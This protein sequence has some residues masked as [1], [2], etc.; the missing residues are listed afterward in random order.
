M[1]IQRNIAARNVGELDKATRAVGRAGQAR[2]RAK[3]I[4][5]QSIAAIGDTAADVLGEIGRQRQERED[6]IATTKAAADFTLEV[7]DLRTELET[8][9]TL[10]GNDADEEM[11]AYFAQKATELREKY[12]SEFE[13]SKDAKVR[14]EAVLTES[15]ARHQA[16]VNEQAV[17]RR[18]QRQRDEGLA[19]VDALV[20]RGF[21][22]EAVIVLEE[23]QRAGLVDTQNAASAAQ[24]IRDRA[25]MLEVQ[26][27]Y[28]ERYAA[29]TDLEYIRELSDDEKLRERPEFREK[30]LDFAK[31]QRQNIEF[32]LNR[33]QKLQAESDRLRRQDNYL[34][35][36]NALEQNQGDLAS[37]REDPRY[38]DLTPEQRSGLQAAA[39]RIVEGP[40][41]DD[42]TIWMELNRT[43]AE[44][45]ARMTPD[46]F[47]RDYLSRMGPYRDRA[48]ALYSAAQ[49]PADAPGIMTDKQ[50]LD[51]A[52][53]LAFPDLADEKWSDLSDDERRRVSTFRVRLEQ[54]I[55][56]ATRAKGRDLDPVEKQAIID[57]EIM[58]PLI[59]RG[60]KD[61]IPWNESTALATAYTPQEIEEIRA[62]G[63]KDVAV[64]LDDIPE[65]KIRR[66]VNLARSAGAVKP[67]LPYEKARSAMSDRMERAFAAAQLGATDQEITDILMG[68]L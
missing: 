66:M 16:Q 61:W 48:V 18:V 24:E 38:M 37:V 28:R 17:K 42:S 62:G 68:R 2:A 5:G 15:L 63:W 3:F 60:G 21:H 44:E 52:V 55:D 10:N 20:R 8:A 26:E 36:A 12:L 27:T 11:S 6:T 23:M 39:K 19:S 4:E 59:T 32:D 30:V 54:Q 50:R 9:R 67:D 53:D 31:R 13:G 43:P 1:R 14:F 7:A 46:E 65:P 35:L 57:Q 45:L 47:H 58:R 49:A 64:E 40:V 25:T 29:G 51:T 41:V 33:E 22:D 34:A 56:A